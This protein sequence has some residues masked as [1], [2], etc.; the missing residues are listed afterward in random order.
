[1]KDI[2][3][4]LADQRDGLF[5]S[6]GEFTISAE[7]ALKKLAV[8]QLHD[9]CLWVLKI[10]QFATL[11]QAEHIDF[12]FDRRVTR[13]SSTLSRQLFFHEFHKGLDRF[14]PLPD[15]ALEHLVVALRALGGFASRRF[16]LSLSG[17][18]GTELLTWDG[19]KLH[20]GSSTEVTDYPAFHLEVTSS[21]RSM[22][23]ALVDPLATNRRAQEA[24]FLREQGHTTPCLLRVD[25]VREVGRTLLTTRSFAEPIWLDF[26]PSQEGGILPANL[27]PLLRA[28]PLNSRT[29]ELQNQFT[30]SQK[31]RFSAYWYVSFHY[32]LEHQMLSV[33][34]QF[35]PLTPEKRLHWVSDGVVVSS[36]MLIGSKS[37]F[38]LRLFV[39]ASDCPTD[40]GGL[41]FRDSPPFQK[42]REMISKLVEE[43]DERAAR[44]LPTIRELAGEQV[45][46]WSSIRTGLAHM[47]INHSMQYKDSGMAANALRSTSF[48]R[49]AILERVRVGKIGFENLRFDPKR[50]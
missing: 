11:M 8:N 38:S 32:F 29:A 37:P 4:F 22:L 5:D 41:K 12:V 46:L 40:I 49:K 28:V 15:R 24:K 45:G 44:V 16:A 42:K 17:P 48:V 9:P 36:E 50:R 2:N 21:D 18:D 26:L 25:G 35:R 3:S 13:V 34:P 30:D 43:I 31:P 10:V 19:T 6:T 23:T 20:A 33:R 27:A 39:D 47:P 7:K 14:D 1:M